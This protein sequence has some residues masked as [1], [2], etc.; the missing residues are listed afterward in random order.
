MHLVPVK[1]GRF[2]R[3]LDCAIELL[4]KERAWQAGS[5]GGEAP[6]PPLRPPPAHLGGAPWNGAG[7]R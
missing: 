3:E 5:P 1:R 7:R 2:A 4:E 6:L